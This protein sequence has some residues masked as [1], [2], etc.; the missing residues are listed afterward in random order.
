[1]D[2]SRICFN[3]HTHDPGV[4]TEYGKFRTPAELSM[5]YAFEAGKKALINVGSVGQPRDGDPRSCYVTIEGEQL[6]Y[7][8]VEYDWKQ[9]AEKIRGISAIDPRMGDRLGL[10][11]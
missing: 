7:H 4:I 3:G 5:E 2:Q 10:G 6:K 1:M 11:R 8:R 9:T